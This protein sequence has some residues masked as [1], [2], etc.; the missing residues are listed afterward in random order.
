MPDDPFPKDA[1]FIKWGRFQAG[2]FGRLA[3]IALITILLLA[4]AA[5]IGH[6]LL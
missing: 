3:I 2:A 5:W 4:I 6:R 1:L